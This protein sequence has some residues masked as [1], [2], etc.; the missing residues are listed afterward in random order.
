MNVIVIR[1]RFVAAVALLALAGCATVDRAPSPQA[2]LA[3]ASLGAKAT[4]VAWPHDDW[5]HRYDDT[6]LDALIG[7]GLAGSPSLAAAQARIARA[8]AAAGVARAAL[9]PQVNGNATANYQRYSENYIFPPPLGGTWQTDA[10]AT[11][12]FTYEIDFWGKNGAALRAALS[13]AQSASAEDQAVRAMLDASV[14][15]T[16]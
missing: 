6:Q 7:E 15:R 9:L 11:L 12:D 16:A 2:E 10:R 14:T 3:A 4:S 8:Q 13:Q 1:R 5:W